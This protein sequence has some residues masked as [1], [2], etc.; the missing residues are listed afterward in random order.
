[1]PV[2][3]ELIFFGTKRTKLAQ[4]ADGTSN[5]ILAIDAD[6]S[7]AATWTAPEGYK[8]DPKNPSRGLIRKNAEGIQAVFA[9]G[10]FRVIPAKMP[11]ETLWFYFHPGDGNVIPLL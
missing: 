11:S 9:I 10:S 5:T 6:D 2:S 7:E 8:V 4:I 3:K 1:M